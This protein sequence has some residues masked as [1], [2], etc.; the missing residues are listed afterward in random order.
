LFVAVPA[1][2]KRNSPY[3]YY[4]SL[5]EILT[6]A[7]NGYAS[8]Y[9]HPNSQSITVTKELLFGVR[10]IAAVFQGTVVLTEK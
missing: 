8:R 6:A 2:A 7:V 3:L 9:T 4:F 1:A 5:G 10:G